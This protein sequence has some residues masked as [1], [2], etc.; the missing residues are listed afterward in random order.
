[1]KTLLQNNALELGKGHIWQFTVTFYSSDI[2]S[3][4]IFLRLGFSIAA[5]ILSLSL[6]C[7][8]TEKEH[9][10]NQEYELKKR[11]ILDIVHS[12]SCDLITDWVNFTEWERCVGV[13]ESFAPRAVSTQ[14]KLFFVNLIGHLRVGLNL[15]FNARLNAKLIFTRKVLHLAS[16]WKR[17]FLE[18]RHGLFSPQN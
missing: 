4:T 3:S 18:L 7:L 10:R 5:A 15:C 12:C 17:D 8:L 2:H 1:M 16:F 13:L 14:D 6:I 11:I 9:N